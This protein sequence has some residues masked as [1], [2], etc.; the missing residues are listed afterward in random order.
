[1]VEKSEFTHSYLQV[2]RA[3]FYTIFGLTK[4]THMA[5]SSVVHKSIYLSLSYELD[6]EAFKMD[7]RLVIHLLVNVT[8]SCSFKMAISLMKV[9]GL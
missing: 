9:V 6:G 7:C 4:L 8:S 5:E 3:N 1:M 2:T